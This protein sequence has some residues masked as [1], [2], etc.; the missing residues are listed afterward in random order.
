MA[1]QRG[2]PPEA[3]EGYEQAPGE[4]FMFLPI[5]PDCRYRE[6]RVVHRKCCGNITRMVCQDRGIFVTRLDCMECPAPNP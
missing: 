2:I 1:P 5:L 4:P 3:P 6:L